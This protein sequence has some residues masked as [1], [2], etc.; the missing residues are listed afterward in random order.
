[1]GSFFVKPE[2][3][4]CKQK[5][6][7][8]VFLS[9][10]SSKE[11]I[12]NLR[13]II[14]CDTQVIS[15]IES[16]NG[17]RNSNEIIDYSDGILIDAGDL[18]REISIGMVTFAVDTIWNNCLIKGEECFIATNILD[19]MMKNP[20]PYRS[21]ISDI[22]NLLNKGISGFVLAAEIAIGKNL[23]SQ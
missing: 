6:I 13:K 23:L 19:S 3:K 21:E 12:I 14:S 17:L 4:K 7:K 18:S 15:K 1:M 9:F 2:W 10:A 8:P 16:I 22:W 11:D 5:D 20:I